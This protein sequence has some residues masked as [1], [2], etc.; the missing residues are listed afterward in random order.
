M[1]N[2]SPV[3][4]EK[5]PAAIGPYS[6]AMIADNLVFISG[7]L[8]FDPK[9]MELKEGFKAQTRQAME[10]LKAIIEEAE[11]ALET[12]I[13]VDV[14]LTDMQNFAVFNDIYSEYFSEHKPARIAL[15]VAGLPKGG[16]VEVRCVARRK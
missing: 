15:A 9:T 8:G 2:L 12:V 7:Q 13:N 5:A 10:N 11:A 3:N 6:Q 4:T 16:L 1:Q 14:F